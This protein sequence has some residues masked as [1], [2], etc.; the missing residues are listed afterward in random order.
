MFVVW[1]IVV[2]AY[3]IVWVRALIQILRTSDEAF[4]R[5]NQI[6]WAA[7]VVFVPLLGLIAYHAAGS[8]RRPAE[9]LP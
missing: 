1:L 4:R 5:G 9:T 2:I 8:P 7:V 6:M 3:L